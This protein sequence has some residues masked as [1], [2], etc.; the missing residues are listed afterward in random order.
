MELNTER[1]SETQMLDQYNGAY[2]GMLEADCQTMWLEAEGNFLISQSGS[3]AVSSLW[4]GIK[5]GPQWQKDASRIS[6]SIHPDS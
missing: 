5:L 3:E 6:G 4:I 2:V 1:K